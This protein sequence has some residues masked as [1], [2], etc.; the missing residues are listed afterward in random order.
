MPRRRA[1]RFTSIL[2]TS[3]VRLIL[4]L[5]RQQAPVPRIDAPCTRPTRSSP[6]LHRSSKCAPVAGD[7]LQRH[8]QHEAHRGTAL[9]SPAAAA[10]PAISGGPKAM[11]LLTSMAPM[12]NDHS[13][14]H[15]P[16]PGRPPPSRATPRALWRRSNSAANAGS[17]S[18]Q[19]LYPQAGAHGRRVWRA[20]NLTC[21]ALLRC[22]LRSIP[23]D[24]DVN[25]GEPQDPRSARSERYS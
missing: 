20:V 11:S 6:A 24:E 23:V 19:I 4:R 7:L 17:L 3:A 16:R 22:I 21:L 5:L 13:A 8:R 15:L 1:V 10:R 2:T 9:R 14:P 12:T 18:G 25:G